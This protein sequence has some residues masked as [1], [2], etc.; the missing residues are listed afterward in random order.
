M[1]MGLGIRGMELLWLVMIKDG[2]GL[3]VYK[4]AYLE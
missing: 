4:Y 1:A 3:E 2:M